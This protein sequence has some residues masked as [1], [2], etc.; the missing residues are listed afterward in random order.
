MYEK[1]LKS[2]SKLLAH[3]SRNN[4][5]APNVCKAKREFLIDHKFYWDLAN[6]I[7]VTRMVKHFA[8]IFVLVSKN[9]QL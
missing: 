8:H 6:F 9:T 2:F 1:K 7:I 5:N 4:Y 3:Q